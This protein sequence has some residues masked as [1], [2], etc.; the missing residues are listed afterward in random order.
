MIQDA[1]FPAK[2]L[3]PHSPKPCLLHKTNSKFCALL[4]AAS[5]F[6]ETN[7]VSEFESIIALIFIIVIFKTVA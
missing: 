5:Q 4:L 1:G 2:Y 7:S 6:Q 3:K